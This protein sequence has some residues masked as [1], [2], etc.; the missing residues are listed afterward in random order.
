MSKVAVK[1]EEAWRI[2]TLVL[3][4]KLMLTGLLFPQLL[5]CHDHVPFLIMCFFLCF[6]SVSIK[7]SFY[8][9][10][11]T[12]LDS[13]GGRRTSLFVFTTV[14][15]ALKQFL[16]F[17]WNTELLITSLKTSLRTVMFSVNV[18]P[19]ILKK[20]EGRRQQTV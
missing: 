17:M 20:V 15:Y 5:S 14:I 13:K 6:P 12:L 8:S 19:L 4:V 3:Q 2:K 9:S 16:D 11:N 7:G 10:P 18:S 1:C